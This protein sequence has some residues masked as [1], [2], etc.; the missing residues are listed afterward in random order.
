MK[1][2]KLELHNFGVYAGT[3]T[4][5]L[6]GTKPIVLI[7]GMNGRGKTTFLEAVLLALYGKNSPSFLEKKKISYSSYL[8]SYIN[9]ADKT[10]ESYVELVFEI[11]KNETYQIKRLWNGNGR[12]I[13]D[14]IFV[15]NNGVEN[16]FLAK[17]WSMFVESILPNALSNFFFFDGEKIAEMAIDKDD[18]K[19]KNSVKSMLGITVLD[20]LN[21]D[22]LKILSKVNK[23]VSL[24]SEKEQCILKLRTELDQLQNKMACL[25]DKISIKEENISNVDYI[26]GNLQNQ[27]TIKGG[28]VINK[29]KELMEEK[30]NLIAEL[31]SINDE[32]IELSASS[33]PL[34]LV[35]DLLNEI[36][37]QSEDERYNQIM[38]Q[39]LEM[40]K[41]ELIDY[42]EIKNKSVEDIEQFFS[43]VNLTLKNDDNE[44]IY[45][46]SDVSFTQL[47]SILDQKLDN[48]TK[49]LKYLLNK[50]KILNEKVDE[51]TSYLSLDINESELG[52]IL[53]KIKKEQ[54]RHLKLQNK[55]N[56]LLIQYNELDSKYSSKLLELN[57]L[58]EVYLAEVETKDDDSRKSKYIHMALKILDRYKVELQKQKTELLAN[59][60]TSCYIKLANKKNLIATIK[61]DS[62]TLDLIYLNKENELISRE[63]LSAGEK[64]LIVI[65]TLWAL[66]ICSKKKLPVIIDTPLARLDSKHRESML[67]I[68][69][70]NASEQT[71]ILSTDSEI[72]ESSYLMIKEDIGNEFTLVYDEEFRCTS[73]EKGYFK[74][75]HYAD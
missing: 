54:E 20:T 26:I 59:T 65:S 18:Q 35:I 42:K 37:L 49:R 51:L 74:E 27:Y 25:K 64:Q 23:D 48:N 9:V 36:K 16:A 32:L 38:S 17:N 34:K 55:C 28:D 53:N 69:F 24:L 52:S 47:T 45:N 8:R 19:V 29:R 62:E 15:Y 10:L 39:A 58:I 2:K 4:F 71:I 72:D 21:N 68:Y 44:I 46:L 60:I 33:L 31:N 12:R 11:N 61:M 6:D 5:I 67:K 14:E 30:A 3:N 56:D 13:S 75:G 43:Y 40:L 41:E 1:I 70:P 66:A 57:K 63:M 73:V 50:K 22:L 7:G